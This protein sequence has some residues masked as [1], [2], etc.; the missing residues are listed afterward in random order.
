M[1]FEKLLGKQ[2]VSILFTCIILAGAF[3]VLSPFLLSIIWAAIIATA[4]WP[5]HQWSL[6]RCG[7]RSGLAALLTTGIISV[8]LVGPTILLVFFVTQDVISVTN[9]LIHANAVGEP[10]PLWVTRLPWVGEQILTLWNRYLA[11]PSQLSTILDETLA[12][13]LSVIQDT[14]Q[15]LLFSLTARIATLFFALWVLYFFYRDG[16]FLISQFNLI[17]YKWLDRRWPAY[18]HQVPDALRAAVNG[19]VIVGFGEAVLLSV[20]YWS[21]GVPSAVLFGV[22]TAVLAFVPMAAPLLLSVVGIIMFASGSS[23]AAV[24]L[25]VLGLMI[26]MG[27]D[28]T[29]RPMLIQGGTQLPFLG[30]LFG[31]FGGVVTMGIVGLII[32]PVILVLLMVFFREAAIDEESVSLDFGTA[33][34]QNLRARTPSEH[35]R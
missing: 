4:S 34:V 27:A 6:A 13:K 23:V 9:Y 32:G 2:I 29:I 5:L 3:V 14:A 11:Q 1:Q 24:V 8:L 19:L 12:A 17:G 35:E 31:I 30:I 10:A 7:Q 16:R 18:V 26:V 21:C 25:V 22:A 20:L 28:Y 33:E 15:V